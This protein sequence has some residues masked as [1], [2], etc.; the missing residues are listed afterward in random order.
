MKKIRI[1]V[2]LNTMYSEYSSC[3]IDGIEEYCKEHGCVQIIYPLLRGI[4]PTNYDFQF[5]SIGAF[6]DSCNIDVLVISTPTIVNGGNLD[7]VCEEIKALPE[8]VKVSL[9]WDIPGLPSIVV[10]PRKAIIDA[11]KHLNKKHN[12][13]KFLLVRANTSFFESNEREDA[14]RQ[15]LKECGLELKDENI[16]NGNFIFEH[17]Y[18]AL[19]KRIKSSKKLDFDAVFCVNDNMALACIACL[20]DNGIR[21]PR[22]VSLIG[23]DNIDNSREDRFNFSTIDQRI[24]EQSY[25][26]AKIACRLFEQ[27]K[28]SAIRKCIN[29]VP[30][31]RASCGCDNHDSFRTNLITKADKKIYSKKINSRSSY[32]LY[33]L[34][35]FLV[36]TQDAVPLEELYNRL[37]F[38]F[39]LFD[40]ENAMLVL[41]DNP[42]HYDKGDVFAYPDNAV[43]KMIYIAGLGVDVKDVKFNPHVSMVPVEFENNYTLSHVIFPVFAENYQYGYFI[44]KLGQYEKMFY[45]S[46]FELITKEIVASIKLSKAQSDKINLETKN[47]SLS[48]YSEQ[49]HTLSLTDELTG[50]LNRR[51]FYEAAEH[52]IQSYT[53]FA[54]HGLVIYGDMD[55]LKRINDT[56]GHEAGDR[57][58]KK[59]SEILRKLFRSSDIVGR[60]GGDEFAII[61]PDMSIDDFGRIKS[62]LEAKCAE[63]NAT[64]TDPFVLS[65]S[66]GCA[67]FSEKQ[68]NLD[69]LLN[70]ADMKLYEEKRIKKQNGIVR[71]ST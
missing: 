24:S 68:S 54:K 4:T 10:S 5:N 50:L 33:L 55:G 27:K 21:V 6:I 15:G 57:A 19:S 58:I 53:S 17:A 13:K 31:Y 12:R 41:Y 35:V 3:V 14:F 30:I 71:S 69:A 29:A 38:C 61:A 34:H 63:Y 60:L 70:E 36:E 23:F 56:F 1:G 51:G 67:E 37:A 62:A 45:Q 65:I 48:A 49:L 44:F 2:L 18:E 9:G 39:T 42:V 25:E 28:K 16:L 8:M 59:E 52:T 66:V 11:V 22:D 26:A 40:I 43:L 47:V 46:M 7:L 64:E 20:E 32:Q